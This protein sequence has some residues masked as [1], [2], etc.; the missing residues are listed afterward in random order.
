MTAPTTELLPR[1]NGIQP[2]FGNEFGLERLSSRFGT[3]L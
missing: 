2:A 3:H 1:V